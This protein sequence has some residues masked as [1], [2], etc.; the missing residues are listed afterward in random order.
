M[1]ETTQHSRIAALVQEI[2][3]ACNNDATKTDVAIANF[4]CLITAMKMYERAPRYFNAA[5]E[6]ADQPILQGVQAAAQ[7]HHDRRDK[8]ELYKY[9]VVGE[10]EKIFGRKLKHKELQQLGTTLS[11][12]IGLKLDRDTKRSKMAL[13][14]WFSTHW[15]TLHGKIYEFGLPN[16]AFDKQQ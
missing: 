9:P 13:I 2:I 6:E 12:K 8:N 10:L 11:R 15:Q 5:L 1:S 4:Q 14:Q 16:G 7:V 3:E